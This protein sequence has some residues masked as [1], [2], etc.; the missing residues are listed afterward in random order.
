M[1]TDGTRSPVSRGG[2]SLILLLSFALLA[3]SCTGAEDKPRAASTFPSDI[4]G[5]DGLH[6]MPAQLSW[7]DTSPAFDLP[8]QKLLLTGVIYQPDGKTP[9][10]GVVLYYYQTNTEGRYLHDPNQPRSMTPNNLGQT[11]GWIRGWVKTGADGRYEIRTVRPGAYPTGD[12]VAHIHA[13]IKEPDLA[14]YYIDDFV[15]D[16]DR[17][18]N[19][20]RRLRLENR[21]GSGILRLVKSGDLFV[22]ERDII[23]GQ[24]IPRHPRASAATGIKVGEDVASFTP[25]HAWGPD[26]GTRTCPVCKYGW[27]HGVLLF[28]GRDADFGEIKA[29]LRVLEA[30]SARRGGRLK[31]FFVYGNEAGYSRDVRD[32]ELETIGRE[33][34]LEHVALT[35][36]PSLT[37][38]ESDVA[39]NRIDPGRKTTFVVY[40]RSRVIGVA[41]ELKPDDAGIGWVT[42]LLNSTSGGHFEAPKP[43]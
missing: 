24:N 32:R 9:A 33:L 20:Q 30:E 26:K 14:P 38:R 2:L 4:D 41:H 31:V 13:T 43:N 37:D 8:G 15:F 23:L 42:G 22:G 17:L 27:Y 35:H 21:C 28:A 12:E 11:H 7:R 34:K 29:W 3:P 18:L 1:T 36:L 5:P 16:D 19:T 6:G 40:R 39:L 25:F 10:E